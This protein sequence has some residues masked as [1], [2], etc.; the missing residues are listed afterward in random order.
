MRS[1]FKTSDKNERKRESRTRRM[2]AVARDERAR[3]L[4]TPEGKAAIER[5][6]DADRV[7]TVMELKR[8][9]K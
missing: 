3:L 6:R 2:Q 7:S 5:I 1:Y 9:V 4:N 8:M